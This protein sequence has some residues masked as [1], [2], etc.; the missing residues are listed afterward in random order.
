MTLKR[1]GKLQ[2]ARD[3][4][5]QAK[6]MEAQGPTPLSPSR[7]PESELLEE[8]AALQAEVDGS[9]PAVKM[10]ELGGWGDSSVRELMVDVGTS[11]SPS[12][13]GADVNSPNG[14]HAL[15]PL[16]RVVRPQWVSRVR[17]G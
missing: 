9:G 14:A 12:T 7:D 4:L 16:N 13:S 3:V 10:A 8:F 6:A 15:R 1:A 11:L 17:C 2:E 5:R